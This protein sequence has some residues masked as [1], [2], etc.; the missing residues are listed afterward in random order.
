MTFT[1]LDIFA[2]ASIVFIGLPHGAFD[3]GIAYLLGW[4]QRRFG[5][6]IFTGLYVLLAI[7]VIAIWIMA[8]TISL[9]FF[10]GIS[11]VHFGLGDNHFI[12][13]P[14]DH[15]YRFFKLLRCLSVF[16]HGG[17][18]TIALPFFHPEEVS[19]IF[20]ILSGE[21]DLFLTSILHTLFP[22]WLAAVVFYL[23]LSAHLKS[24]RGFTFEIIMLTSV[25]A[26]LPPLAG[27]ALY[28]CGI[29]TAR[30]MIF[31]YH[32][33]ANTLNR[34]QA[35][36]LGALFSILSWGAGCVGFV[37]LSVFGNL[38]AIEASLNIIFIGLAA[39]TVPHMLLVDMIFRPFT[40]TQG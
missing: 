29:H 37:M 31:L 39:L 16:C 23:A 32:S 26:I 13:L 34:N 38:E 36:K 35:I 10:L 25:I 6:A 28:F 27:F 21:D 7:S 40:R 9:V 3:G 11:L 17:V 20:V 2:L 33:I 19:Q 8:P 22:V 24:L 4:N 14:S 18:V 12:S 15:Q 1:L 5:M 30:H